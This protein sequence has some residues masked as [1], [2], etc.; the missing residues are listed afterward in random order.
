MTR[1]QVADQRFSLKQWFAGGAQPR[2]L[3]KPGCG[4]QY[5]RVFDFVQS[6]SSRGWNT[7]AVTSRTEG[8]GRNDA[9]SWVKS[10]IEWDVS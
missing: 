4:H 5:L 8:A 7:S 9:L 1:T 2:G 10:N 3:R 6:V